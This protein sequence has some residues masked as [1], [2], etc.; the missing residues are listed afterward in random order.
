M[1]L[2]NNGSSSITRI[3]LRTV[4]R[5]REAAE[6]VELRRIGQERVRSWGAKR[7][8]CRS[9]GAAMA[10]ETVVRCQ[11]GGQICG[12]NGFEFPE[13][14]AATLRNFERRLGRIVCR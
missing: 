1:R 10:A 5:I 6:Q 12:E 8:V 7:D 2:R 13:E 4:H 14:L 9:R 11:D 3:R